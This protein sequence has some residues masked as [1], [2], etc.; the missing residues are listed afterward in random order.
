[1]PSELKKALAK[2][3]S[4]NGRDLAMELFVMA[5]LVQDYSNDDENPNVSAWLRGGAIEMI[6]R[7]ERELAELYY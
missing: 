3:L 1:M 6:T 2:I 5:D 4:R 7:I